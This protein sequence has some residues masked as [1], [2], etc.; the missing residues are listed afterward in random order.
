MSTTNGNMKSFKVTDKDGNVYVMIPVDTEARQSID[1]AKN[2]QFDEDYFTSEVSQDQTTVSVGL[3]GVPLGIDSDSPL[4]FKQDNAQGIVFGS[5]APFATAI[6]PEYSAFSTYAIGTLCMHL[7]KLYECTTAIIT[8]EA[9]NSAHWTERNVFQVQNVMIYTFDI[10]SAI[11]KGRDILLC[12]YAA[13]SGG[14]SHT[15]YRLNSYLAVSSGITIEFY[16]NDNSLSYIKAF[17][18]FTA[19]DPAWVWSL[20]DNTLGAIKNGGALTDGASVTVPNNALST[21]ST[22][23]STLTLNINVG[24][25]EVPNFAVE[26]SPSADC[27]LTVTKTV[28]GTPTTLKA[29]V[30]G[31]NSLTSGKRYQVTCVGSCWT[32]AEFTVPTP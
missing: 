1:E 7:G 8:A 12:K 10:S 23:Q 28:G 9:W 26:V 29:S 25:N 27:T 20:E 5:D 4:K 14:I 11:A 17:K 6:A 13:S 24:S 3:N 31:G 2:L 18:D 19:A 21:L 15:H 32:L 16:P 22:A 30:A